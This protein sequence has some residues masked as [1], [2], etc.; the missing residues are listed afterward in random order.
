[1]TKASGYRS[2]T[3]H[4]FKRP[5]RRNGALRMTDYLQVHKIG[6]YVDVIVNGSQQ[7]GMPHHFYH[8]RTGRVF[9]VNPRS[10]GVAL[11][12]T[13]RN[14]KVEKRINVRCEHVR[15]SNSRLAFVRRVRENDRLRI[16]ARKA[17]KTLNT[18]RLPEAPQNEKVVAFNLE[19][20][21]PVNILAFLEIH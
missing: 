1:M 4:K 5:F 15:K 12:K 20:I 7:A 2:R 8:G 17:G 10:I 6:D 9:N 21:E 19:T 16:E 18:K 11:M 3:R 14:R 13:V